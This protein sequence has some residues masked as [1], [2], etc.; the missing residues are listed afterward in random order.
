MVIRIRRQRSSQAADETNKNDTT[1]TTKNETPPCSW[2]DSSFYCKTA[3]ARCGIVG[4]VASVYIHKT[5]YYSNPCEMTFSAYRFLEIPLLLESP[6]SNNNNNN[7]NNA[8]NYK[9]WQFYDS[10]DSRF[11]TRSTGRNDKKTALL[12]RTS[13]VVHSWPLGF[14]RAIKIFRSSWD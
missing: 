4:L 10:R 6:A 9:L 11:H 8:H 1:C 5:F 14:L 12:I 13:S 2:K 7:N 3:V